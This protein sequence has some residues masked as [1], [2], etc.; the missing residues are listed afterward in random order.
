[1]LTGKARHGSGLY[2][3]GTSFL[4]MLVSAIYRM[5]SPPFMLG[6]LALFWGYTASMIRRK[7]RYDDLEFRRFLRR[8]HWSCLLHGK[9]AALN[10]LNEQQASVWHATSHKEYKPKSLS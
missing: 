5:T 6:S 3:M 7:P 4:Y 10:Q 1:M 8:F 2:F 9:S